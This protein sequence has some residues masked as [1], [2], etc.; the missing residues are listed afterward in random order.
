M[1]EQLPRLAHAIGLPVLSLAGLAGKSLP[2]DASLTLHR[3]EILGIAGLVGA[4]RT[5]M[6]RAV[7]GLD[8]VI[9][10]GGDRAHQSRGPGPARDAAAG[11][12]VRDSV[13]SARIARRK[14]WR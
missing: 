8:P 2:I 10:G 5:E 4:G 6:L 12:S 14:G 3:G 11:G 13:C 9:R 1:E 7:F